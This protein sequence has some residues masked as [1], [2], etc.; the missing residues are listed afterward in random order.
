MQGFEWVCGDCNS[1]NMP[2][3]HPL[4]TFVPM[5]PVGPNIPELANMYP[6]VVLEQF[7][8]M[9]MYARIAQETNA[10]RAR[11]K[12]SGKNADLDELDVYDAPGMT[13]ELI[14]EHDRDSD[15]I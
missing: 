1:A 10:Y 3:I 2:P 5:G 11:C 13:D 14:Q 12:E 4:P 9:S 7:I 8:P 6:C 15:V